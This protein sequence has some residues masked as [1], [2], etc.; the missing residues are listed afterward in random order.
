MPPTTTADTIIRPTP[1]AGSRQFPMKM[2]ATNAAATTSAATARI[3][4]DGMTACTSVNAAPANWT[5][6]LAAVLF[7]SV[8]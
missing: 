1:I 4:F 6:S 5:R 3:A 2:L 7:I 8:E